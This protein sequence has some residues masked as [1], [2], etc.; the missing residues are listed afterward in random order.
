MAD[1]T[2]IVGGGLAGLLCAYTL[3]QKE[4]S[5][6]YLFEQRPSFFVPTTMRGCTRFDL[7]F[8]EFLNHLNI[9]FVVHPTGILPTMFPY[10]LRIAELRSKPVPRSLSFRKLYIQTFG[11]ADY[12][13]FRTAVPSPSSYEDA[14]AGWVLFYHRFPFEKGYE[15]E[16]NTGELVHALISRFKNVRMF[17]NTRIEKISTKDKTIN[18]TYRYDT[19]IVTSYELAK[20]VCPWLHK[21]VRKVP[22]YEIDLLD[23]T[24]NTNSTTV[25]VNNVLESIRPVDTYS[26]TITSL[27]KNI[28]KCNVSTIRELLKRP[29]AAL[30]NCNMV[31][32]AFAVLQP[33]P[34]SFVDIAETV[35]FLQRPFSGVYIA[36]SFASLSPNTLVGYLDILNKI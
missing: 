33:H 32:D 35:H 34:R 4:S 20:N 14:D 36:G 30:V 10:E 9:P 24:L 18:D 1:T 6:I 12:S 15:F 21:A 16:F 23:S 7:P 8:L 29:S 28:L 3:S 26:L 2:C 27:D 19:L 17:L 5:T 13:L 31:M 22:V 25:Y 11:E